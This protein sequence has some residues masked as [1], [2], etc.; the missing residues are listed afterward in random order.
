[1][2]QHNVLKM[3]VSCEKSE[4]AKFDTL[5]KKIESTVISPGDYAQHVVCVKVAAFATEH[6]Q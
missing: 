2:M 4:S 5:F 6:V 3:Y 1:M